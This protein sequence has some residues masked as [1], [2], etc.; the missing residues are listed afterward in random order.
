M[1]FSD[2]IVKNS[3]GKNTFLDKEYKKLINNVIINSSEDEETRW[4]TYN[5]IIQKK[6]LAIHVIAF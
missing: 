6:N 5:L 4:E 1:E 2:F 3:Y